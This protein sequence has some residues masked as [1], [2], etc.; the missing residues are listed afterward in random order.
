MAS[1]GINPIL[2]AKGLIQTIFRRIAENGHV[3]D[4]NP[5]PI[6]DAGPKNTASIA[7]RFLIAEQGRSF[8]NKQYDEVK[9]EAKNAGI[10][11]DEADYL[12][13]ETVTVG[14]FKGFDITAK[15]ANSSEYADTQG[16]KNVIS[17][18][19]PESKRETALDECMKERKGAVT[20]A[21]S[22]R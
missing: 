21:V 17:K 18:Y 10:L 2:S 5:N 14:A 3:Y 22:I 9:K 19:V 8:W 6:I 12:V 11:G 7:A 1:K 13:G 16:T 15:K 20:I 4:D